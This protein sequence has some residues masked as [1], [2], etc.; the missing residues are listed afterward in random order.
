MKK[1]LKLSDIHLDSSNYPFY[2][3]I[4]TDGVDIII[5]AGDIGNKFQAMNFIKPFLDKGIIVIYVLGNHEFYNENTKPL[6]IAEIIKGWKEREEKNENLYVLNNESIII[7][8]IKFIGSTGWTN[9]TPEMFSEKEVNSELNMSSDFHKIMKTKLM[10][11]YVTLRG[12]PISIENYKELHDEAINYIK[13]E[14]AKPFNGTKILITHHPL[15][16]NSNNPEYPT[17]NFNFQLY[18]SEYDSI[19]EKSD[20]DYYFHGHVHH[21]CS[22]YL[23]GTLVDCNAYGYAKYNEVNPDHKPNHIFEVN[24]EQ[25]QYQIS[26]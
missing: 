10:K 2:Q 12:Y 6:T 17:D 14:I 8:G 9:I 13:E 26:K 18:C 16:K 1:I 22:Y 25:K 20:L 15:T 7:D 21:S 5:L 23:N 3:N 19:I 24:N 4:N 11:G